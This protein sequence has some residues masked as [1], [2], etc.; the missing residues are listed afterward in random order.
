MNFY[1]II[2]HERCTSAY[3]RTLYIASLLKLIYTMYL[4]NKQCKDVKS[5]ASKYNVHAYTR[6]RFVTQFDVHREITQFT[7]S[8]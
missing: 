1:I 6:I 3:T 4:V 2:T 7:N 8:K 5:N